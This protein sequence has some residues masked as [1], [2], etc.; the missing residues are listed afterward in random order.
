MPMMVKLGQDKIL[1]IVV[2]DKAVALAIEGW[3]AHLVDGVKVV[4]QLILQEYADRERN[5][6]ASSSAAFGCHP[7]A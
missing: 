1:S 4:V 3:S 6:S 5:Q 7:A 2:R